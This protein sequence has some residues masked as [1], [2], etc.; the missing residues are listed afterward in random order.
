MN[1]IDDSIL[2]ILV[3]A[4]TPKFAAVHASKID[5]DTNLIKLGLIDSAD[6]L[7]LIVLVE[8]EVGVEFNPEGLD[9]EEGLTLRRLV[10]AFV[11]PVG[12]A[13]AGA[14]LGRR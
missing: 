9:L 1:Q 6:L 5:P 3:R 13:S 11:G 2:L 8:S 4:L 14:T 12:S 10:S 7:E